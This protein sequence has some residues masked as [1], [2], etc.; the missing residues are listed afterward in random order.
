M[1]TGRGPVCGM[2]MRGCG[3]AGGKGAAG[4]SVAAPCRL[5]GGAGGVAGGALAAGG[6]AAG[7]RGG[8]AMAGGAA[9]AVGA[10]GVPAGAAT[11]GFGGITT[12]EGGRRA[13]TDAGVTSFGA[14]GSTGAFAGGTDLE[15][16]AGAAGASVLASTGA[17]GFATGGLLIGRAAGCSAASFCCV[18]A[19]N[20]SPGRAICDRSIL[21]LNSSSV[22]A[23]GREDFAGADPASPEDRSALRTSSASCSSNELECVF[24]SVTPTSVST[25]RIALLLTSS[26]RARS[27][28]RIFIRFRL[29]F[30]GPAF[31]CRYL[32][33]HI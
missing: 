17:G 10:D 15:G 20:T 4:F 8:T 32:R 28:I 14:G 6:V 31:E 25:S 11:G 1:Y 24:F 13:A 30:S 9:F 23:A 2:I 22:C 21:V 5:T 3:G 18:I 12:T 19:R 7:V 27:L 16:G 26:S 33:S 29:S